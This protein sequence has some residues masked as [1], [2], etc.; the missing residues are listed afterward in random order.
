V[1]LPR[2]AT[3]NLSVILGGVGVT[4]ESMVGAYSAFARK[5]L[6][7][8]PRFTLPA[9]HVCVDANAHFSRPAPRIAEGVADEIVRQLKA[10]G[11]KH[12]TLD[13]QGFRSGSLN[14]A[15]IGRTTIPLSL[16]SR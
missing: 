2:G 9:P 3:P 1:E 8:T 4:L 10:V 7:G 16:V 11:F 14:E 13:L 15:L 12:V 5:G 6:S